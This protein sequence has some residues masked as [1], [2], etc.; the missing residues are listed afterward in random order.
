MI[1]KIITLI[2][3][4]LSIS[5]GYAQKKSKSDSQKQNSAFNFNFA[6]YFLEGNRCKNFGDFD[7]A[8]RNYTNAL[9]V[10]KSQAAAYYELAT[11]LILVGDY[12]A[13]VACAENAVKFDKTNNIAYLSVLVV[14]YELDKKIEKTVPLYKKLINIEPAILENYYELSRVYQTINKPKEA[15]KILNQAEKKVGIIDAIIV[16]KQMIYEK[17]GNKEMAVS[18]L[19]R[20]SRSFPTNQRYKAMLAE[21]YMQYQKRELAEKE[22]AELEKMPITEGL[23]Y[24]SLAEYHRTA[25][26]QY[27]NFF[28]Y[29]EKAFACEDESVS[30]ELKMQMLNQLLKVAYNDDYVKVQLTRLVKIMEKQYPK[31]VALSALKADIALL[32]NNLKEAQTNLIDIVNFDKTTYSIFEHL[33]YIDYQLKDFDNLYVHSKEATELFPNILQTYQYFTISAYLKEQ[34]DEVINAVNYASML[35]LDNQEIMVDLLSM[36][37]DAYHAKKMYHQAD[38]VYEYLLYKDADYISVLNNYSYQLAERGEKLQRALELSTH[39][40]EL[41][42]IN[43]TYLDT[44][45]WVLFKN[46]H[47][48]QAL[49]YID[50]AIDLDSTNAIYFEHRGDILFTQGK[51]EEAVVNWS[52]ALIINPENENVATKIK[53]KKLTQ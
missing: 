30:Y 10:D 41:D 22:F 19:E 45:A 33:M 51:E 27:Y 49:F 40:M 29:L 28:A 31:N 37:G 4:V 18:E 16:Q 25:D 14:A 26:A 39:L 50:K 47:L 38:S 9:G 5:A 43:A 52:E 2:L 13:A 34:F 42:S 17:M 3:I 12:P 44:H 15:I 46:N 24:L 21:A 36:Q 35:S 11:T 7:G 8:I 23:I 1:K 48:D 32:N 53:T 20:L 6:N